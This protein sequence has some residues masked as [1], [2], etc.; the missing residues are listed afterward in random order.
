[1]QSGHAPSSS[2][3][4]NTPPCK[5]VFVTGVPS[6]SQCT[7]MF[8]LAPFTEYHSGGR[9]TYLLA[10]GQST[11]MPGREVFL[12]YHS[13]LK[14]WGVGALNISNGKWD[15][16]MFSPSIALS[17]DKIENTWTKGPDGL[18]RT[19]WQVKI[20]RDYVQAP[21]LTVLCMSPNWHA[22]LPAQPGRNE[23]PGVTS[24][25]AG[26]NEQP[27]VASTARQGAP[28]GAQISAGSQLQQLLQ[29]V[30]KNH[31]AVGFVV[32]VAVWCVW[33]SE[34]TGRTPQKPTTRRLAQPVIYDRGY[35]TVVKP[36]KRVQP[37]LSPRPPQ[38]SSM[39]LTVH[40]EDED[41]V[42]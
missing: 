15:L 6:G 5:R 39:G 35:S 17:P 23:Q 28:A 42:L 22:S 30:A 12:G 11:C 18:E 3:K 31:A 16:A 36:Q 40:D 1:M 32:L 33:R 7:G 14:A 38:Q 29:Q 41:S 25:V 19:T 4:G 8:S 20:G 21:A 26:R 34:R 13:H 27:G 37:I 9:P 2:G 10:E 24:T